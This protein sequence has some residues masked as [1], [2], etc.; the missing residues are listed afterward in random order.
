M[1]AIHYAER[2]EKVSHAET[3]QGPG[4]GPVTVCAWLSEIL[5]REREGGENSNS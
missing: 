5:L 3:L 2:K 4:L 1:R